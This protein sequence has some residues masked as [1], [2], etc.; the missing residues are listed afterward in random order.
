VNRE[1]SHVSCASRGSSFLF[2]DICAL[3]SEDGK[4]VSLLAPP[5]IGPFALGTLPGPGDLQV[6]LPIAAGSLQ[7]LDGL[8]SD[9]QPFTVGSEGL[10]LSNLTSTVIVDPAF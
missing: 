5:F 6:S 2:K 7:G 9:V 3:W 1:R 10:V 8:R 4:G